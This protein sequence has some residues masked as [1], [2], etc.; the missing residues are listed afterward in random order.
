[1]VG[2]ETNLAN[3]RRTT[4]NITTYEE[5]RLTRISLSEDQRCDF[6]DGRNEE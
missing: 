5:Q 2:G 1:M 3:K 4:H 6:P